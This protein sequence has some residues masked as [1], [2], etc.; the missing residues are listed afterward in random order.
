M[1]LPP[2]L[3]QKG[4]NKKGTDHL[5]YMAIPHH[6]IESATEGLLTCKVQKK[7]VT[8]YHYKWSAS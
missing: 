5:R 8:P 2:S 6:T 4:D 7:T 1:Y 3:P